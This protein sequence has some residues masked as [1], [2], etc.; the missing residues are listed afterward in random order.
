MS[1]VKVSNREDTIRELEL[2]RE[3]IRP[4]AD[5]NFA[6]YASINF[7]I[8]D[9]KMNRVKLELNNVQRA[10]DKKVLEIEALKKAVRIVV[11]KARQEGVSTYWQG[12]QMHKCIKRKNTNGLIVAHTAS[13]TS[14]IL[15]KAKYMHEKM[16]TEEKPEIRA[17]NAQEIIFDLGIHYKGDKIGLGSR[18][19]M[20]T[21]GS[22]SL[23]RSETYNTAHLSEYAFWEGTDDKTPSNQL[24]GILAAVPEIAGT[25]IL[26]ESTA[27]GYNDFKELWDDAVL[28]NNSWVPMFFAW[29][30]SE[31]YTKKF[32]TDKEKKDFI[33]NLTEYEEKLLTLRNNINGEMVTL[34][35]V[36]WYHN[37]LRSY[38][39]NKVSMMKQEFPSTPNE[40]FISTGT[41]IF[42]NEKVDERITKLR[43][44]YKTNPY[45]EG[46][47]YFE[48]NDPKHEDFI[49]DK[50]I[51]F[52]DSKTQNHVRMY[53]G[54]TDALYVIGG[55]TAGEGA[56]MYAGQVI[57]NTTGHRVCS[58]QMDIKT[59]FPFTR[60]IYCL[61]VYYNKALIGVEMNKNAGVVD[62]LQR[63]GYD[64]QYLRTKTDSIF[65]DV[66]MKYGYKTDGNTK[67]MMIDAMVE[68]VNN[69]IESYTDIPTLMEMLTYIKDKQG[70]PNAQSGKHDDLVMAD[71]V[72]QQVRKQQDTKAGQV[73]NYD[74]S[75]L[76]E[77]YI[78]DY[79]R[80]DEKGQ[81]QDLLARWKKN[82]LLER[83]KVQ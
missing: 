4:L 63:L 42:D 19:S 71:A 1:E 54:P 75:D 12:R 13:A 79:Y 61:G 2:E 69:N 62:E 80:A 67:P 65:K 43:E 64:N 3:L 34:E 9:K 70:H 18:L 23:G 66:E 57:D 60:Q 72:G 77:D 26:I 46:Y 73:I 21:A 14:S 56:D 38:T 41:P 52:I 24:S 48:W 7:C 32:D 74:L 35:Q 37:K 11:L 68:Y 83:L 30:D 49:K 25:E 20:Q 36:N 15:G 31:D 8:K 45:R 6:L 28:G 51:E 59:T 55:D 44:Y 33:F 82:G 58:L 53:K 40:A 17:S 29:F 5:G 39:G 50:S 81:L 16:P 78:E 76:P 22:T 27:N 10:I 47:F